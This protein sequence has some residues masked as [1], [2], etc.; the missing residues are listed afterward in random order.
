MQQY[1]SG[2]AHEGNCART[3]WGNPC[4]LGNQIGPTFCWFK[5]WYVFFPP[6]HLQNSSPSCP[7]ATSS[8]FRELLSI[9][10][11]KISLM[12]RSSFLQSFFNLI[13]AVVW[14]PERG[15]GRQCECPLRRGARSRRREGAGLTGCS[16]GRSLETSWWAGPCNRK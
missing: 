1:S 12:F 13:L 2:G 11:R 4:S 7:S 14:L 9:W 16:S 3:K 8:G 6:R 15:I 10:R 5:C